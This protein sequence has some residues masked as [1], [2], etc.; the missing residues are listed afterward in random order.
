MQDILIISNY[1]HF[2]QEKS[3]S[4]Y[5]SIL[6]LFKNNYQNVELITSTFY[7]TNK[8][9]RIIDDINSQNLKITL[10]DEPGY[11][12][13]VS[14]K[15]LY[16]H[17][18]FQKNVLKYLKCRKK[19][20]VIYLF[21]PPLGLGREIISFAKKNNIKVVIDVLDLWPQAFE[22]VLP[23]RLKFLKFIFLPMK[24]QASYIYKN[25][26]AVVTVSETYSNLVDNF[27]NKQSRA[28]TLYIGTDINTNYSEYRS[29]D[30]FSNYVLAYAGTLGHS[31]DIPLVIRSLKYLRDNYDIDL[32]F[33]IY[34]DGPLASSFKELAQELQVNAIFYGR[35]DYD[36][37]VQELQN[38]DILVN[39][40]VKGAAQSIINKHADYAKAGRAVV[41]TQN[42]NEYISLL[43]SYNAGVSSNAGDV[44]QLAENIK[45]LYDNPEMLK[46]FGDN[47][48]KMA[49]TLFDRKTTYLKLIDLIDALLGDKL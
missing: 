9:H 46:I 27:R 23:K 25:A 32:T 8:N 33:H 45:Y 20:D 2:F 17:Y 14:F 10:L 37:M 43:T 34:G 22:M 36:T 41:N 1:W 40:I 48:R 6:D 39:P 49:E 15:R 38:V 5:N 4:R 18:I 11:I 26:D 19:P 31:Y 16:S 47:Q 35:L 12:K 30:S 44:R 7:H 24:A 3:S 29:K 42:S 28:H 21:V 13:N